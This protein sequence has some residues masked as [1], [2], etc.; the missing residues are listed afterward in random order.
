MQ[1]Q[2]ICRKCL[3]SGRVQGVFFRASTA[4]QARRLGLDG[5]AINLNDG[6]VEVLVEGSAEKVVA[7]TDWLETGPPMADVAEVVC[8]RAESPGWQGFRTG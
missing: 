3:V 7:L 4:D 6:R 2:K 8:S 1:K 5:H